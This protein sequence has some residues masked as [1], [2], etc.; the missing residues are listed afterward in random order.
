MLHVSDFSPEIDTLCFLLLHLS[1]PL[2]PSLSFSSSFPV[3]DVDVTVEKVQLF[4]NHEG[5]GGPGQI[6]PKRWHG[7]DAGVTSTSRVTSSRN[8]ARQSLQLVRWAG[9][10]GDMQDFGCSLKGTSC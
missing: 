8:G 3:W 6:V 4:H 10:C 9:M 7:G 5:C 1:F 2:P